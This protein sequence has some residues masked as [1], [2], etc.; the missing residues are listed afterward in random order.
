MQI[1]KWLR[2]KPRKIACVSVLL[3]FSTPVSGAPWAKLRQMSEAVLIAASATDVAS[4]WG[5]P[6]ANPLLASNGRFGARGLVIKA[7]WLAA[8][9]VADRTL[10]K[11]RSKTA[12]GLNTATSAAYFAIAARNFRVR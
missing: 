11:H 6:E 10:L 7:S 2:K 9:L 3:A 8:V 5:R 4:S 1:S 12:V